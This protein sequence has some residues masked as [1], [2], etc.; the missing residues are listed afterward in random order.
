[1]LDERRKALDEIVASSDTL[2]FSTAGL[3][4]SSR[5]GGTLQAVRRPLRYLLR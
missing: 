4:P 5:S 2:G 1:M 3:V